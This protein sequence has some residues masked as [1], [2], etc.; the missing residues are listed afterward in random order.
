MAT[1]S[2]WTRAVDEM[3]AVVNVTGYGLEHWPWTSYRKS[4]F[5]ESRVTPG[6]QLTSAIL[7]SKGRV[8]VFVQISGVNHYGVRGDSVADESTPPSDDYLARLTIAW[9][10]ATRPLEEAGVRRIVARSGVILDAHDG[11]LPIMA[12]PV[13]LYLG[14]SLG[15]GKQAVPWIHRADHA[16]ALRFLLENKNASGIYNLVAPTATSNERFM[17][18]LATALDRP[19]WLRTPAFVLRAVLG[20]MSVLVVDGRYCQPKRLIE[21]GYAF[22][23]PTI[24]SAFQNLLDTGAQVLGSQ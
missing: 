18:A 8:A 20:E 21:A 4:R 1:G 14:G 17:R 16:A 2:I 7:N 5:I 9:E 3:D 23:F 6:R 13:R 22:E 24:E 10:D 12:L 11:M 19:F 15:N